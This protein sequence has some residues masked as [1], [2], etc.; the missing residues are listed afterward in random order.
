MTFANGVIRREI[1]GLVQAAVLICEIIRL[2][3]EP[4]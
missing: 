3:Y 2:I 4:N 1:F